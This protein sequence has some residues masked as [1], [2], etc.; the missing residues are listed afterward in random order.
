MSMKKSVLCIFSLILY[1]LAVCTMLSQKIETEMATRVQ[2]SVRTAAGSASPTNQPTRVLFSDGEGDH[3]YEVMEGTGW[4]PG[5]RI[6]EIP[7]ERWKVGYQRGGSYVEING[8]SDYRFVESA[9][10]Q[11][12]DGK[13][14]VIVE[15]FET[16]HDQYLYFYPE[17][18]PAEYELPENA[19]LA[20]RS[21]NAL[22][23]NMEQGSLPF[24][25]HT[26]KKLTASTEKADRA[27]SLTEVR[28]F[29][30]E[31]PCAAMV[32]MTL[33]AGIAFWGAAC[34]FGIRGDRKA[35]IW[36][37]AVFMLTSLVLMAFTLRDIELPA[38]MLPADNIF[39][40][41]YYREELSL[42]FS[43]LQDFGMSD[44]PDMGNR[45]FEQCAAFMSQGMLLIFS[46]LLIE[47]L[48]LW[49][50]IWSQKRKRYVGKYLKR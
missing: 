21:G 46:V 24:F 44:I 14:A 6:H 45:I 12:P 42:I 37:N 10:R 22:L 19:E 34:L 36:I 13:R 20:A 30:G 41:R 48:S 7:E 11:P 39:D 27:F 31:L 15:E 29:L 18:M 25:Q 1:L 17:G 23:M 50:I 3:L 28:Q 32:S 33:I 16:V 40:W 47:A 35:F 43:A 2:I 49:L 38:S 4:S 26:A 5:L 9:S 8:G